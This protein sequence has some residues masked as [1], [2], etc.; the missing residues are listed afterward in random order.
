CRS[1]QSESGERPA[2]VVPEKINLVRRGSLQNQSEEAYFTPKSIWRGFF[3]QK[4]I[5]RAS[6][7]AFCRESSSPNAFCKE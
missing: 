5:W 3:L 7:N 1:R 4:S 6:P 2:A